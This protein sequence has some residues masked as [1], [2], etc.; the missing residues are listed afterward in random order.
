M[1]IIFQYYK[2]DLYYIGVYLQSVVAVRPRVQRAVTILDE[3]RFSGFLRAG[4]DVLP[5]AVG[6]EVTLMMPMMV[7]DDRLVAVYVQQTA[8]RGHDRARTRSPAGRRIS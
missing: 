5:A 7:S 4:A 1:L 3:G 6:A 8:D 2:Y